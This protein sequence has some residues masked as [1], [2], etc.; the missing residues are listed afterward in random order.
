MFIIIVSITCFIGTLPF[1]IPY[2][3]LLTS[4]SKKT[5]RKLSI[6]HIIIVYI[7][8]YY[9]TG[10]LSFTG[11]ASIGDI[12]RNSFG[13]ITPK[14]LNISPDE[15]NL[16]PFRWIA[17]NARP[18]MENILLFIPLGFMLPCIWKKYEVLWK[19]ALSGVT[20]SFII[21]LSQLF[22]RRITDIDDLLMNT[23]GALIGWVTF[24]L[25][26]KYLSK[27]QDRISIQSTNT[28]K[29]PLLL[30]E[31]ACFYMAIAFAGMLFVF[32]PFL[33]PLLQFVFK[34][35]VNI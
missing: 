10:V 3:I 8:V 9:L 11:I 6:E 14:G 33:I 4:Q 23:L 30:H 29:I 21:E 20:F 2:H 28:G 25:L 12:V 17:E 19:T 27:L 32:Y 1:L 13:I 15:I 31:E 18:Y 24:R 35:R 5:G 22:N 16:I 7:F 26:K 34:I